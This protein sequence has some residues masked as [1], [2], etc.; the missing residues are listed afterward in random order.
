MRAKLVFLQTGKQRRNQLAWREEGKP[1]EC[2]LSLRDDSRRSRD[3]NKITVGKV[4]GRQETSKS[5]KKSGMG[6]VF[7][8]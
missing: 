2:H 4:G 6:S 7:G 5:L 1:T 8:D 3:L